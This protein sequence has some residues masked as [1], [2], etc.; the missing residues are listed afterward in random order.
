MRD[1]YLAMPA[2]PRYAELSNRIVR[3][4]DP[5]FVGDDL[6]KAL[7]LKRYLEQK[8]FYS[9]KEKTLVGNDPTAKFLFGECRGYCVHFA[10]AMALLLR[11]QGIP[12]RVALGYAVQTRRHGA[13]S[14]LLILGNDAH[15]WPEMYLD[16]VGWVTIDVYPEHSDEPPPPPVDDDLESTLGELA[17]KDPTGGHAADPNTRLH[18]PW[19]LIGGVL[20]AFIGGALAA[21]YVMKLS[22]W[23]R[24]GSTRV[25]YVGVL[26]TLAALGLRRQLGETREKHA[27]RV[28]EQAPSFAMLTRVHLR[29]ALGGNA[30]DVTHARELAKTTRREL[31]QAIPWWRRVKAAVDPVSWLFTR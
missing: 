22:R 5:R 23:L 12:S 6:M 21:A 17:R 14:S 8:G 27:A 20:L 2:D 7:A 15:A 3:D 18:I 1:H 26:D 13:G 4:M 9:L 24:R 30:A 28:A 16:G 11:S 29:E 31:R 19:E 10:H 25:V